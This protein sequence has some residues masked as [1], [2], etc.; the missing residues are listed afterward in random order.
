MGEDFK[1]CMR[2]HVDGHVFD[3]DFEGDHVL[4]RV[5]AVREL[6]PQEAVFPVAWKSLFFKLIV[7][8]AGKSD[9]HAC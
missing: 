9:G 6:E 7:S 5:E 3:P 4:G 2:R 8:N 1:R